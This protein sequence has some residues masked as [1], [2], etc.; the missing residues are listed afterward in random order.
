[1]DSERIAEE[2]DEECELE[3]VEDF[4]EFVEDS[5]DEGIVEDE[6]YVLETVER[7]FGAEAEKVRRN[8]LQP[9]FDEDEEVRENELEPNFEGV[10]EEEDELN[11]EAAAKEV[12]V[13]EIQSDFVE[14]AEEEVGENELEPNVNAIVEEEDDDLE[15]KEEKKTSEGNVK[16]LSSIF[17]RVNYTPLPSKMLELHSPPLL[18]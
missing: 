13:N 8:E 10:V 2:G 14:V 4:V 5:L 3:R 6:D 1:M 7:N 9:G 16:N 11:V 15:V 18:C 12:G 17:F